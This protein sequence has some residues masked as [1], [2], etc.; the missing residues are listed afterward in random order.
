M[1]KIR[2]GDEVIVITGKDKGKIAIIKQF[3]NDEKVIVQGINI[4]KKHVK[5]D[6]NKGVV[7]G[8]IGYEKP[9][10]ISNIAIYNPSTKKADRIGFR[11]TEDNRKIRFYKATGESV[12][13]K[14]FSE[15][16]K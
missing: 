8:I 3:E 10:H 14:W 2:C 9:I 1:K 4:V 5:P 6:P 7:G 12:K 15:G 13:N 11:F 16:Y